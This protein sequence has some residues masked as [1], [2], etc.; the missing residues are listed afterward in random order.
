MTGIRR[1]A[2]ALP[3]EEEEYMKRN[4]TQILS[5]GLKMICQDIMSAKWAVILLTV[6]FAFLK[7]FLHSLCP[8]VLLTGFPC[9]GCGLTRAAFR[10]LRFDFTGAWRVHPFI[11]A[12]ILLAGIFGTERYVKKSCRMDVTKWCAIAVIAGMVIFYVWR[13]THM[14]PDVP[15]MTYYH[16]NLLSRLCINCNF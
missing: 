4:L 8:M 12:L 3:E 11:F 1:K 2:F 16:D 9:P 5:D 15:P 7:K 10:V 13:M 6:Y 14:F